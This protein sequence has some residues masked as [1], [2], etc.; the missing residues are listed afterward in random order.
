M[1]E[2]DST[3]GLLAQMRQRKLV[4]WLLAYAAGAWVALQVLGLMAES[5]EWPRVVMRVGF[6][7]A[8]TGFVLAT[9]LAWYHGERGVQ[10]ATRLEAILLL[11]VGAVGL[12]AT[13]WIA[14]LP[15]P[16]AT[17]AAGPTAPSGTESR[18]TEPIPPK[19]IAVLP[20]ENLSADPDNAF[21]A[22][23]IQDEILTGLS[24]IA[25]LKVISRTSTLG[26]GSKPGNLSEIARALGVAKILEG[27]VQ[28][29]GDRVRVNVQLIDAG[30]DSHLWADTYDRD[31]SDIFAV[32]SEIAQR[33]AGSLE[34]ALTREVRASLETPPTSNA[35]AYEL[36]LKARAII[37]Q[38]SSYDRARVDE[39]TR[40][41]EAAVRLDPGF[42]LAWGELAQ[43]HVWTYFAGFDPTP[44]RLALSYAAL[45]KAESLAPDHPETAMARSIYLYYGLRDFRGAMEV[46]RTAQR[47]LPGNARVWYVSALLGRRLGQ[48]EASNA[49]FQHARTLNPNDYSVISELG[50]SLVRQR[51]YARALPL[52]DASLALQPGD[53]AMLILRLRC[54]WTLQGLA[55]GGLMLDAIASEAPPVLAMRATQAWY[56]RDAARASDLFTRALSGGEDET[57]D[58]VAFGGYIQANLEWQLLLAD[59]Q[60]TTDPAAAATRYRAL[61]QRA[62][63]E[64]AKPA[65]PFVEASWRQV[66][67]WSLA[68]LG[69]GEEA[70]A[71]GLRAMALV[72]E[73]SDALEGPGVGDYQARIYAMNADARRALPLIERLLRTKGSMLTPVLL[74]H[75]PVWD[76]IRDDPRFIQLVAESDASEAPKP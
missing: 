76:T 7:L 55:A 21:F 1:T 57:I 38:T 30:S 26:Y 39:S 25:G 4:Q 56:E 12:A 63:A 41:L 40:A 72:P 2:P 43:Q 59:I 37:L 53:P 46:I 52:L 42:A 66:R 3:A 58:P 36:Y 16:A 11:I 61:K 51:E 8:L 67:A 6:G 5:F 27:S 45:Q 50:Y 69:S 29:A 64:L 62:D 33:I 19:S 71:E 34:A 65:A 73:G 70:V 75:D 15:V 68:G 44:A 28:K 13:W 22:V 10:R 49:D 48:W 32:Q 23:G 74:K 54:V 24:R 20:F 9:V 31:L 17:D 14:E 60:K 47:G 18:S 35:E